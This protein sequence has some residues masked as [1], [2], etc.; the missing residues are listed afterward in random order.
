MS[1]GCYGGL[2]MPKRADRSRRIVD[3]A[4]KLAA[5]RGW[6]RLALADIAAEAGLSILDVYAVFRSKTAILEAFHHRIDEAA[7][8]GAGEDSG[9]RSRDRLFDTLMRR[10]DA[11]NPHKEAVRAMLREAPGDPLAALLG[12]PSLV[13]SMAWML[14]ISGVP[15]GGWRGR[16]RAKL[17]LGIYLSVLREWLADDSPDMMKTM[18]ALDGRLRRSARWLGLGAAEASA[19]A[20]AA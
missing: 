17:L 14:E 5:E 1:S 6:R 3:A 10:F 12:L 18:A 11:L 20:A 16:L 9:E 2:P 13:N 4:L 19:A 7:M 15:A 8:A